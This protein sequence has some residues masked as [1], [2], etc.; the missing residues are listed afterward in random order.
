MPIIQNLVA[1]AYGADHW[2]RIVHHQSYVPLD[3]E[4]LLNYI[5]FYAYVELSAFFNDA[6]MVSNELLFDS[7]IVVLSTE[8][9]NL[10][11]DFADFDYKSGDK[12]AFKELV[13]RHNE[14]LDIV[15]EMNAIYRLPILVTFLVSTVLLCFSMLQF[16]TEGSLVDSMT[17]S[18]VTDLI[19]FA[20]YL[21]ATMLQIFLLCF[22]CEKL[23]SSCEN[24]AR[25]IVTANW[26]EARDRKMLKDLQIVLIK[27]QQAVELQAYVFFGINMEVFT[28]VSSTAY[29]YFQCL[30]QFR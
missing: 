10:A 4:P 3:L 24:V 28:D 7:F 18:S 9:E 21:N 15:D 8:F 20:S 11:D 6:Y 26:Y 12:E 5:A 30:T 2:E 25:K 19:K 23:R 27:A 17:G 16:F 13:K 14:L 29:S 22:F 1:M